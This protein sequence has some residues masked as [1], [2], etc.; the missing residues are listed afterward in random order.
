MTS[1]FPPHADPRAAAEGSSMPSTCSPRLPSSTFQGRNAF[2]SRASRLA[3][4]A[5]LAAASGCGK[6]AEAPPPAAARAASSTSAPSAAAST[7]PVVAAPPAPAAA[8]DEA[9]VQEIKGAVE[10]LDSGRLDDAQARLDALR[11]L[12]RTL[13]PAVRTYL[14]GVDKEL[15]A[16]RADHTQAAALVEIES[17]Q[18]LVA[19]GS[20]EEVRRRLPAVESAPAST[21]VKSRLAKLKQALRNESERQERLRQELEAWLRSPGPAPAAES[22]FWGAPRATAAAL[23][24][25]LSTPAVPAAAGASPRDLRRGLDLLLRLQ[26]SSGS[27]EAIWR[28]ALAPELSG[29]WLGPPSLLETHAEVVGLGPLLLERATH[30]PESKAEDARAVLCLELLQRTADPPA[31]AF[32]RL[33]ALAFVDSPRLGPALSAAARGAWRH[34]QRDLVGRRGLESLSSEDQARLEKLPTRLKGLV[35][36]DDPA[37]RRGARELSTALGLRPPKKLEKVTVSAASGNNPDQPPAAL[38][39][40]VWNSVKPE[41]SW[42]PY[43]RGAA[44]IV[45]DL[46]AS[47]TLS[48]VK[49]WNY[50][51]ADGAPYGWREG[52]AVVSDD[53]GGSAGAVAFDLPKAPGKTDPLDFGKMIELPFARGRYLRL[54][55]RTSHLGEPRGGLTEAELFTADE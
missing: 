55:C 40:G 19:A 9:V 2:V 12:R 11:P 23:A 16:L 36:G 25:S 4:A 21:G 48:H 7:P 27:S 45:L 28:A 20:L 26:A 37:V 22:S 15:A 14:E 17:L 51:T 54:E 18:S 10:A 31:D 50:N 49:L 43:T 1:E 41:N 46:G 33:L 39:D 52:S 5:L 38:L 34:G 24:Q 53:P 44:W 47:R 42:R 3:A 13:P 30:S 32:P 8:P 29:A 6:P 35:D